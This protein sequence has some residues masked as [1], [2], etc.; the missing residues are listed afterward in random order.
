[1]AKKG[2]QTLGERWLT[3]LREQE[4]DVQSA[5]DALVVRGWL[6]SGNYA[7]NW[8]ISGRLLRGY[9]LGH[10]VE[11]FG[12]PGTG[13]SFLVARALGMVQSQGGVAML[14]DTEGAY[15]LEWIH[16]LGVEPDSLAYKRSK[17]VDDHLAV[18]QGYIGAY[19]ALNLDLPGVLACDSLAL[20]ST[21]HEREVGLDKKDMTKA[22]EMKAFFR[23]VGS[24]LNEIPSVYIGTNHT[25]AQIGGYGNQRTTGGGG[26]MKFQASVRLDL[27][28]I[29]RI[30]KNNQFT[31]VLCR[32]VVEKNRIVAPW[33]EVRLAIPFYKPVSRV[34]GL[35]ELLLALGALGTKGDYITVDDENTGIKAYRSKEN[36]LRQ[37]ESAAELLEQFPEFLAETDVVIQEKEKE[38]WQGGEITTTDEG[39]EIDTETGEVL[40]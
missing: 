17:I 36:F 2:A 10:T 39:E 6:D 21:K 24:D 20:L 19:K 25:I 40:E 26:G 7:L 34:S 22:A 5:R 38:K 32:V 4:L 3:A 14:D 35:I 15:N 31:G 29:S 8:A 16:N 12:D 9:P 28:A 13:K 1:M 23:I 11:I 37:D 18:A 27:R 30:K 33:K